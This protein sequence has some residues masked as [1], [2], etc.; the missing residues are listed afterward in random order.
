MNDVQYAA[1]T[2]LATAPLT[3]AYGHQIYTNKANH[4]TLGIAKVYL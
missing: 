4:M 3:A 2:Q 1:L